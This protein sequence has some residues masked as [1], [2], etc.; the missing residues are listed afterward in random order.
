MK[1]RYL[2]MVLSLCGLALFSSC[3]QY[4]YDPI[5]FSSI[6]GK[7]LDEDSLP[8]EGAKVILSPG[9]ANALSG[10]DGAFAFSHL[11]KSKY[12]ITAQKSGYSTEREDISIK[13][14]ETFHVILVLRK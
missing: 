10:S 11:D 2:L 7:V 9:G 8:I 5:S 14:G 6:E 12:T 3:K 13:T 4:Q 1:A